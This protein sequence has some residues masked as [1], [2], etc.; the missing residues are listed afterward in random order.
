MPKCFG[1]RISNSSL[2]WVKVRDA[3]YFLMLSYPAT[4]SHTIGLPSD[5]D[6]GR[7]SRYTAEKWSRRDELLTKPWKLLFIDIPKFSYPSSRERPCLALF[8]T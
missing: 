7:P 2:H 5:L 4:R 1:Q 8:S 6:A 3:I